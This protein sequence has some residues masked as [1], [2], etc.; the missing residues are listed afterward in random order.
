[1]KHII[2]GIFGISGIRTV[3]IILTTVAFALAFCMTACAPELLPYVPPTNENNQKHPDKP[4]GGGPGGEDIG[5]P[6]ENTDDPGGDTGGSGDENSGGGDPDTGDTS[7]VD[8]SA[9][10]AAILALDIDDTN[11]DKTVSAV[12]GAVS[13][14]LANGAS[15]T[16]AA[17]DAVTINNTTNIITISAAGTYAIDG[18]L[19]N[20]QVL[21]NV[22]AQ[23]FLVLNGVSIT[24]G[25]S[26]PLA[27]FGS[28]KKV[29]TLA[30]GTVNT[31]TDAVTYTRFF[32]GEE[33]NA[34]LFAKNSL[35]INGTGSLTVNGRYNNGIGSKDSLK[36]MGGVINVTAKNN[37]LKGNDA[38][39]IKGGNFTLTAT[40]D[41]IKS[42]A[43]DDV[44]AGYIYIEKATLNI[45]SGEDG[46]Q[47]SRAV[48]IVDGSTNVTIKSGGGSTTATTGY[49]GTTSRKGIKSDL[50][51]LITGG[52][53]N[54][55][56]LD[57]ALH[58][59]DTVLIYGGNFT[60]KTND[61]GFH[62]D[63]VLKVN[64][65]T[66]NVQKSY[67]GLEAAKLVING[68]V[69][70]V[71]S[72]DDGIN[73]SDGTSTTPAPGGGG[74]PGQGGNN[75][76]GTTTNSNVTIIIT[77]GTMTIDAEGDGIDSNS[78]VLVTGGYV[79]VHGPAKSGNEALDSDGTFTINGGKILAGEIKGSMASTTFGG[80]QKSLKITFSKAL[81]IGDKIQLRNAAGTVIAEYTSKK[82]F[83]TLFISTPEL[84]QNSAWSLYR[85]ETSIKTG[86]TVGTSLSTAV[87]VP[88]N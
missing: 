3:S 82:A 21:V 80:T 23:V 69:I 60:I 56:A 77:G 65:G 14:H 37:A 6:G 34:A 66:I 43:E 19:S 81:T 72:S 59:N 55:D 1:M 5:D 17:S 32:A 10:L 54:I 13:I 53:F 52:T 42:D 79:T 41:A 74:R 49:S 73:A 29:I 85:N 16:T 28:K 24:S 45:T 61:D 2:R 58:S 7:G 71:V 46:M 30:T 39:I 18:T 68:G 33:P 48:Y 36:I 11:P 57:D 67:E 44:S 62:A 75:G 76:G 78:T 12:A 8:T 86:I 84:V 25:D 40:E 15:T 27:I 31:L 70:N 88:I 22:D 20:G 87:S 47:A 9:A 26:A 83:T 51:I 63:K 50:Y 35:T 38:V 4:G 64:D